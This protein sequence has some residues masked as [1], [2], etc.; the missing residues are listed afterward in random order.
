M[1]ATVVWLNDQS[2]SDEFRTKILRRLASELTPTSIVVTYNAP[3]PELVDE[4]VFAVEGP[5]HVQ[6]SWSYSAPIWFLRKRAHT[7]NSSNPAKRN[8][9]E[10]ARQDRS[11]GDL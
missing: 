11:S 9:M 7:E 8:S 5:I 1:G 3:T 6:V 2:F 10:A 4:S